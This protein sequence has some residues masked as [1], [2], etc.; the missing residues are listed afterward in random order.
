MS[1][2]N[3][4]ILLRGDASISAHNYIDLTINQVDQGLIYSIGRA[5]YVK[6]V[7]IWD[8]ETGKLTDFTTHFSFAIKPAQNNTEE[9][10]DGLAFFLTDNNSTISSSTAG[11][12]LGLYNPSA[13]NS[14]N[15]IIAVEFDTW[16]NDWEPD[17]SHI[18]IDINS[19]VSAK[20]V[21]WNTS[22]KDGEKASVWITYNSS[23]QL[24]SV[25]LTYDNHTVFN[26][27]SPNL[28]YTIDLRK[29]L[30]EFVIVGF[31]AST[32]NAS[33]LHKL[34]SW[35]FCS[36]L[37][38]GKTGK[39]G[40]TWIVI[41][42]SCAAAIIAGLGFGWFLKR[43]KKKQDIVADDDDDDV[44]LDAAMDDEFEME[45]GPKRF[46]YAELALATN[47]FDEKGKLG[48]GGFGGV[49]RGFLTDLNLEVAVK[50]ISKGS[51][52]GIKEYVSEVKIIG[53]LRHKNLVQLVG[54]CHQRGQLLL[55]YEFM[56]NGSLDSYLYR[57]RSSMR[58]ELRYKVARDLAYA[59]LYLHE[60][61]E[62][63]VLHRDVKSSN[64]ILDCNF[65]AKLG[66]FGLARLV[67]HG[68]ES[69][70]TV[71]AGTMGYMAPE[72][73]FTGKA[74]KESDV[75]SFGIVAL[76]IACG[77][78]SIEM[79]TDPDMVR[80]VEWVW[81]LY[82][83]GK[84][85]E[86]ADPS[87]GKDFNEKQLER[88][89][90]V[91]L[92]CAHPDCNVRPSIRQAIYVLNFEASLPI[93]PSKMPIPS[94]FSTSSSNMSSILEITSS[95]DTTHTQSSCKSF[96]TDS[97]KLTMSPP[98]PSATASLLSN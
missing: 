23:T 49:Y 75:Y 8:K 14:S 96:P 58:W 36:S 9:H 55:V 6:P 59:L 83:R 26:G 50:R 28:S 78:R 82:G 74:S 43:R 91:G 31:S 42:V 69:Q 17:G 95:H 45:T 52:Q 35:D 86:A 3:T 62:Q 93:L 15:S 19:I 34:Y 32:G 30:T 60:E 79:E 72:C 47:N 77:R 80:L 10:G 39:T 94:Y 18:G 38:T 76:E 5:S 37:E 20:I 68:K 56:P 11:G 2:G 16:K 7:Q 22:S 70:T 64:V 81:E 4:S 89:L 73:L 33:E 46:T 88:L 29:Y 21:T 61:W 41:L 71:L 48:E 24:L 65:N 57:N 87:L 25:F 13:T 40:K 51:K 44:V 90:T 97:S 85:V 92:W 53:R 63:C 12:G 54:W 84:L 66:D 67:E 27:V 98:L 1:Q